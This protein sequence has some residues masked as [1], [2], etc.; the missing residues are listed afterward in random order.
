[1]CFDNHMPQCT[2]LTTIRTHQGVNQQGD[3]VGM[4]I[5]A[6]NVNF[7]DGAGVFVY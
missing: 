2:Q 5:Q 6:N 1:M 7:T 3:P 4:N